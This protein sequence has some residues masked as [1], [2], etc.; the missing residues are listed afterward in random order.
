MRAGFESLPV[1][2]QADILTRTEQDDGQRIRRVY[3]RWEAHTLLQQALHAHH[4]YR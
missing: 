3:R 1:D 4:N 2:L